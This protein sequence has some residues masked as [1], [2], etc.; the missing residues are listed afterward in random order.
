M[1]AMIMIEVLT[2]ITITSL[3]WNIKTK[4][5]FLTDSQWTNGKSSIFST[6]TQLNRISVRRIRYSEFV[7]KLFVQRLYLSSITFSYHWWFLAW[8]LDTYESSFLSRAVDDLWKEPHQWKW[9]LNSWSRTKIAKQ[10]NKWMA[11][12]NNIN[13]FSGMETPEA[14]MPET[15]KQSSQP[16][17]N[18]LCRKTVST[19]PNNNVPR[20]AG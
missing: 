18:Q 19:R 13:R 9:S 3:G 20:K 16:I 17:S 6:I 7:S 4:L 11:S 15:K 10:C 8:S 2:K 1:I 5:W 12:A 14:W